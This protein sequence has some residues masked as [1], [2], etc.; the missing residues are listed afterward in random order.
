MSD[1]WIDMQADRALTH[2]RA[3]IDTAKLVA[4]F[5]AAIAAT[6]VGSALEVEGSSFSDLCAA[7][8][9]GI[10]VVLAA[11]ICLDRYRIADHDELFRL[12]SLRA[13]DNETLAME[14]R[15]ATMKAVE[16]NRGAVSF[17]TSLLALQ[18]LVSVAASVLAANSLLKGLKL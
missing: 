3:T 4:T 9:L 5:V 18:I 10:A 17:A 7:V 8:G 13:W 2:Q 1:D 12:S 15:V 11:V 16:L 14:Y 6:L